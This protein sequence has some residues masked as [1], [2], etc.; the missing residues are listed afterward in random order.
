MGSTKDYRDY[1]LGQLNNLEEISYRPMM[2]EFL[3]YYKGVLIGGIYDNR[4]LV[5]KVEGNKK[6]NMEEELPYDGAKLMCLVSEIDNVELMKNIVIDT[7]Y[8]L[9]K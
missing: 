2:G 4:F 3:I 5:K 6:Y 9:K 7:Y 8:G 1:I